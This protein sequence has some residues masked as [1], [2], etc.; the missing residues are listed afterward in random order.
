MALITNI[1]YFLATIHPAKED[2][3]DE[4]SDVSK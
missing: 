2:L 1:I 3:T 4:N